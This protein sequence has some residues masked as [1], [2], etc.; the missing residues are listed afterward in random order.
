M[1]LFT[2]SI[3]IL[4]GCGLIITKAAKKADNVLPLRN[5]FKFSPELKATK[6][7]RI[8]YLAGTFDALHLSPGHDVR[9]PGL[10]VLMVVS[11][12]LAASAGEDVQAVPGQT[13]PVVQILAVSRWEGGGRG[14]HH[15]LVQRRRF[16]GTNFA[17]V[18]R[19]FSPGVLTEAGGER[20]TLLFITMHS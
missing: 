14:G 11:L 12:P 19:V 9:M 3:S 1:L 7:L 6:K 8:S 17:A 18:Q 15:L 10:S 5:P 20:R 16:L 4:E 2:L 13:R